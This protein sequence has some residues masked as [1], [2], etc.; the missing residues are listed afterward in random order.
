MAVVVPAGCAAAAAGGGST[1]LEPPTFDEVTSPTLPPAPARERIIRNCLTHD[2]MLHAP[3][4]SV[5]SQQPWTGNKYACEPQKH[6]SLGS[7]HGLTG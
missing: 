3:P 5:S 2:L 7:A 4:V 1:A 6:E